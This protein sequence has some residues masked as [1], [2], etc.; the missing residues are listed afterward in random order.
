[1]T[2]FIFLTVISALSCLAASAES[3]TFEEVRYVM[4]TTATVKAWVGDQAGAE[5][6]VDA[7]FA[8][9]DHVDSLMS[10]W[11]DDSVLNR[12][13]RSEPGVWV[14]V[15]PEVCLVLAAAQSLAESSGGAFDPTV[16]PLVRLWGFRGGTVAVPDSA[17]L[18]GT[19]QGVGYR[20][21]EVDPQENRARLNRP[22]MEV[23][24]GGIAKGYALDLAAKNMRRA[25]ALGGVVDL[26]GNILA[27]GS[28]PAARVGIVDPADQHRLTATIPLTDGAA[29]T[30]G[31]YERFLTIDGKK[32]GHI[33]D[34]RTGW[35]VSGQLSVTVV[36]DQAMQADALATAGVVLGWKAGLALIEAV[37]GA[38]GVFSVPDGVGGFTLKTTSGFAAPDLAP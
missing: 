32:Y 11:R 22:Q 38:E 34:P 16:L 35:P 19:L 30:S 28:G 23:D 6:A 33:L 7:A 27:F 2:R 10:T 31:Q 24:L 36:A 37:P 5:S 17:A 13:N 29:A 3:A 18:A 25:G 8:A 20:W 1:M 21:L 9:F 14:Q 26:G 15:G 4:G 12:L